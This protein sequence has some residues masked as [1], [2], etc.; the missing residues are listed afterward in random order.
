MV[1]HLDELVNRRNVPTRNHCVRSSGLCLGGFW[2]GAAS[3]VCKGWCPAGRASATP[4][5][6][7]ARRPF[8]SS[9]PCRGSARRN[10][11]TYGRG[12]CCRAQLP[13]RKRAYFQP[14]GPPRSVLQV[15]SFRTP[16]LR[17]RAVTHDN[18]AVLR[19]ELRG[20]AGKVRRAPRPPTRRTRRLRNNV[21]Q[22]MLCVASAAASASERRSVA[23]RSLS[24]QR[25]RVGPMLPTGRPS[26]APIC[27]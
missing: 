7:P 19:G 13:R 21:R 14:S 3:A 26:A 15:R 5:Q 12:W 9:P 2:F 22:D 1:D 17:G 24:M 8:R 23:R 25:P 27:S 18:P 20:T 11:S 6:V 10:S 16:P 4:M